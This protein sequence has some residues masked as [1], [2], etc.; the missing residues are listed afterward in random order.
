MATER[1]LE[2]IA[3]FERN[4]GNI[5]KTALDL[6]VV[7]GTVYS[8]LENAGYKRDKPLVGGKPRTKVSTHR[9]LPEPG[10]VNRYILTA[11]QNNTYLHDQVWDNLQALAKHY[12]AEILVGTFS[13]N[14]NAY[15]PLAVKRGTEAHQQGL[16]FDERLLPYIDAGDNQ[17]ITLAPGLVW[18]GRF[19]SMPTTKWPLNGFENYTQRSSGIM[20]HAKQEMASVMSGKYEATKFNYSTGTVTQRNYIQK[21]AGLKAEHAHAYG[22]LLVEVDHTGSWWVRQLRADE[23]NWDI[24]DLRQMAHDGIVTPVPGIEAINW[25]DVH[26]AQMD[27][28]NAAACWSQGGMLDT[29]NPKFQFLHDLVD[30][31][32]RNH[33]ETK[34]PHTRFQRHV[35]GEESVE[36]ELGQVAQFLRTVAR[37]GCLSLVVDSNHDNAL[38][39]WL[40]ESD[41]KTDPVNAVYFLE[42]Q[43]EKY[44]AIQNHDPDFHMI[45]WAVQRALGDWG[46]K[47]APEP[48]F[49][50]QDESF[51]ICPDKFG[52]IECGMHGHLGVGGSR[53]NP[54]QFTKMA[55]RANTGHTH[56]ASIMDGIFTAG[57]SSQLDLGYNAG[58]SQWSHSHIITYPNG[59]RTIV[60]V[61]DGRWCA[62]YQGPEE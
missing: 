32:S 9:P 39:R 57:T 50:R 8:T 35:L 4:G 3:V 13:Y 14:M 58:P 11:A 45:E 42:A 25:G 17:D 60:T 26:V 33:H 61:W 30:F 56:A 55:R 20:P 54:R 31:R 44:R 2:V 1:Q 52:G 62:D 46:T 6:G 28:T 36:G 51:I 53:G 41:Y 16:W 22:G 23:T 48:K 27:P 15:G 34:N 47:K 18:A 40:R 12:Q 10:K 24:Y 59:Q 43:L 49:L 21:A 19:N 37:K 38:E 29:L 5:R 7:R